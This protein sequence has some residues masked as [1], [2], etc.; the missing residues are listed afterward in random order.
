MKT[1]FSKVEITEALSAGTICF[2]V[3]KMPTSIQLNKTNMGDSVAKNTS[4]M[5][6]FLSAAAFNFAFKAIIALLKVKARIKKFPVLFIVI[7]TGNC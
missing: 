5:I 7:R 2:W 6:S 4:S 3:K 1:L